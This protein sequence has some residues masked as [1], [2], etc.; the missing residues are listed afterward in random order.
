MR[1]NVALIDTVKIVTSSHPGK[2]T[3]REFITLGFRD[4]DGSSLTLH[5]DVPTLLAVMASLTST[6]CNDRD[7]TYQ[8]VADYR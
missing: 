7:G 3:P 1:T 4:M 2:G 5:M 6:R 8:E